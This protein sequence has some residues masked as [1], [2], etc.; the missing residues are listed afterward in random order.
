MTQFS[1]LLQACLLA[2]CSSC[3]FTTEPLP[4]PASFYAMETAVDSAE[5][6]EA[7]LGL[8]VELNEPEDVFSLDAPP[9]VRVIAV[10]E[11]S[12]AAKAGFSVGDI[13]LSFDGRPTDDPQ[14]YR[15]L[16]AA[17]AQKKVVELE[18]QRGSEVFASSAELIML[19][20]SAA[21]Y[22]Y[23][24]DRGLLR[25]AFRDSKEGLPQVVE[26]A[27]AS[28]LLDAGIVAGDVILLFQGED[29]G[30]A[31][32]FV[33]RVRLSVKPGDPLHFE[34]QSSNGDKHLVTTSAWSPGSVLT[35]IALWPLFSWQRE[36]GADRGAFAIGTFIL[37]DLF[38]Y[39]RDGH[40]SYYSILSLFT[41]ERGELI[42]EE[43]PASV[44][45]NP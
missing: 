19:S 5:R 42:L 9:G 3:A 29:P 31:A 32:E 45:L 20:T 15:Q 33:R 8:E 7:Y 40:E 4:L 28:P 22:L 11:K 17:I 26:V 23:H 13:L 16:L 39:R 25:A 37:T 30:S 27:A 43:A 38:R 35:E 34:V 41:W 2:A 14:R 44:E 18:F 24:V 10:A 12:P 36:I 1:H 21:R 6:Q